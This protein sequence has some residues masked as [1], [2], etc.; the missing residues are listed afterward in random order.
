MG[1]P[2]PAPREKSPGILKEIDDLKNAIAE[3]QMGIFTEFGI[4][5]SLTDFTQT[6]KLDQFK[7]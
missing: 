7:L 6:R 4:M 5:Q 1:A 2:N 3:S